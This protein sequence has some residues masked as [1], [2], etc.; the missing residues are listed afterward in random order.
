M[1][2]YLIDIDDKLILQESSIDQIVETLDK[3][4][5]VHISFDGTKIIMYDD[6]EKARDSLRCVCDF[7]EYRNKSIALRG[8][9]N[10]LQEM[11]Q[12]S[13]GSHFR[14]FLKEN[15]YEAKIIR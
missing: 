10:M 2:N 15:G 13:V 3:E 4:P 11:F 1:I 14:I 9:L 7:D 8:L 6:D 5:S 12:K